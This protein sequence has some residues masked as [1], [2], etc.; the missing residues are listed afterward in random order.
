MNITDE[1]LLSTFKGPSPISKKIMR[2][3]L[4]NPP[5]SVMFAVIASAVNRCVIRKVK[6]IEVGSGKNKIHVYQ[7]I[8]I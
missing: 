8:T 1:Q 2:Q 7:K 6:P 3:R 4:K 5:N